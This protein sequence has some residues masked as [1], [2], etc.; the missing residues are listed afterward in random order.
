MS[1]YDDYNRY[2]FADL[3]DELEDWKTKA[4]G[5]EEDYIKLEEELR[6]LKNNS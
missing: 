4:E 6:E 3:V 5:W 1:N 2:S